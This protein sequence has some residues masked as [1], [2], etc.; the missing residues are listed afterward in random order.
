MGCCLTSLPEFSEVGHRGGIYTREMGK[1]YQSGLPS[2]YLTVHHS[3]DPKPLHFSSESFS[4]MLQG[5]RGER[6]EL[7][8]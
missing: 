8:S 6:K 3:L 1:R 7:T 2:K 5:M 4:T